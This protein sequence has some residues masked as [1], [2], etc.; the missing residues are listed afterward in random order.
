M[1]AGTAIITTRG[2]GCEEVVGEHAILVEPCDVPELQQALRDLLA[3][4]ERVKQLA[5]HGRQRTEALF[6]W[7]GIADRYIELYKRAI[8]IQ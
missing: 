1:A 8:L 2:T 5:Q 4:P 7:S 3:D 6:N